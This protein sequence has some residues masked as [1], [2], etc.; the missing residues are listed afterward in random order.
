[1]K[2]TVTLVKEVNGLSELTF[3]WDKING[4][5]LIKIERNAKKED[6]TMTVP[7]L[8][9]VYQAHVAAV[10][11]GLKYDE[12]LTMPGQDFVAVTLKTQNFLLNSVK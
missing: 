6:A 9:Q 3:D 4:Y 11:T 5:E 10:A 2:E 12:I 1:M 7:A 8:S